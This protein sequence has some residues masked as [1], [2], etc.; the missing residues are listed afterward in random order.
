MI[1]KCWLYKRDNEHWK[2]RVKLGWLGDKVYL[3]GWPSYSD[4]V[5]AYFGEQHGSIQV[6][7]EDCITIAKRWAKKKMAENEF[8]LVE[9]IKI[10]VN[11]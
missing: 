2:V 11:Q 6:S 10:K 9:V 7:K 5:S 1:V 4:D 3:A 8:K